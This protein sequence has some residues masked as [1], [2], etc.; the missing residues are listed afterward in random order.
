M[1][2]P[3]VV[4]GATL[5]GGSIV[6]AR[7]RAVLAWMAA[8]GLLAGPIVSDIAWW[9]RAIYG[10]LCAPLLAV[11][12]FSFWSDADGQRADFARLGRSGR[13][14]V[15]EVIDVVGTPPRAKAIGR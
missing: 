8:A 15:A 12:G 4:R 5:A 1:R 3:D 14:A 7:C 10:I 11:M 9:E 6:A 13:P 2:N